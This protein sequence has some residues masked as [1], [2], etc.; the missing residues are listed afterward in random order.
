MCRSDES[1][2]ANGR[3][4][5]VKGMTCRHCAMSVAEEVEQ[6]PGVAAVEVNVEAGRV[7]VR[8]DGFSDQ[9]I[10]EA[11]DDAGYEVVSS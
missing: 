11:V 6:V 1:A 10:H 5:A 2:T 7:L 9:A 8:G 3:E 4:Y